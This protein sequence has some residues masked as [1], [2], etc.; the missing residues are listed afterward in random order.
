MNPEVYMCYLINVRHG[1]FKNLVV[2]WNR[3][4]KTYEDAVMF[5][6]V[7][8]GMQEIIKNKSDNNWGNFNVEQLLNF[9]N[10]HLYWESNN[11]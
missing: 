6:T 11:G 8:R 4:F 3:E 9:I 1:N 10:N 5:Q 2:R 7:K